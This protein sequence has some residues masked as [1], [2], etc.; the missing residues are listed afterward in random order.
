MPGD[1]FSADKAVI[2]QEPLRELYRYWRARSVA[3]QVPTRASID[4][5]SIGVRLLP[6]VMLLEFDDPADTLRYRLVG[7]AVAADYGRDFTGDA[8]E[9]VIHPAQLDWV[10]RLYLSARATRRAVYSESCYR[11]S[12]GFDRFTYRLYM[13]ISRNAERVDM[14]LAGQ[15]YSP[16]PPGAPANFSTVIRGGEL[17]ERHQTPLAPLGAADGGAANT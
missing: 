14:I 4:P 13:P 3:G 16:V 15:I 8:L 10:R 17:V 6:H 12:L 2:R 7:S 1:D 11:V 9:Q 5:I